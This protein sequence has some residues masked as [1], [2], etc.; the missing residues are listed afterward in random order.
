MFP[1][2]EKE[3]LKKKEVKDHTDEGRRRGEK[4]EEVKRR[5]REA[6][7]CRKENRREES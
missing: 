2:D 5:K 4:E 3:T 7:L 6:R 1:A